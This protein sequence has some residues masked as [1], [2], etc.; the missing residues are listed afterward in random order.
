MAVCFRESSRQDENRKARKE[1]TVEAH[2]GVRVLVLLQNTC[3]P[4]D[5]RMRPEARA[6]GTGLTRVTHLW[7]RL[8]PIFG[9]RAR[10][11]FAKSYLQGAD[12]SLELV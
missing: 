7:Q 9:R 3:Y 11:S 2:L 5:Y 1:K 12:I 6:F 10:W 8:T 4:R